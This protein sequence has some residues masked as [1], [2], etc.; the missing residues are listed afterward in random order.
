MNKK[1]NLN[2][3]NVGKCTHQ[4]DETQENNSTQALSTKIVFFGCKKRERQQKKKEAKKRT[5]KKEMMYKKCKSNVKKLYI[6]VHKLLVCPLLCFLLLLSVALLIPEEDNFLSK[7]LVYCCFLVFRRIGEYIS[8]EMFYFVSLTSICSL[9]PPKT[10]TTVNKS[11][12]HSFSFSF[13]LPFS[14]CCCCCCCCWFFVCLFCFCC[15][16]KSV[17]P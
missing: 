16:Q 6:F 1:K 14:L 12:G 17:P 3:E 4:R 11:S 10:T 2:K 5:D 7:A 15:S 8:L 13:F 9:I